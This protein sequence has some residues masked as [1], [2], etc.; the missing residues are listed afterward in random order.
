MKKLFL[1]LTLLLLPLVLAQ[2]P[3]LEGQS[4]SAT[5]PCEAPN[6][7]PEG[8]IGD[9]LS[10]LPTTELKLNYLSKNVILPNFTWILT[11]AFIIFILIS[12]YLFVKK[13]NKAIKPALIWL[14]LFAII[15]GLTYSVAQYYAQE[16]EG[17]V[18]V[19]KTSDD[20]AISMH[21]HADIEVTV[22][23]KEH[24]FGFEKGPLD[25][26]HTHKEKNKLHWH[27]LEK[28]DPVTKEVINPTE[29]TL[30]SFFEQMGETFTSTCLLDKC[31]GDLCSDGKKGTVT[32]AVIHKGQSESDR[33]NNQEF[34]KYVWKDGDKIWINFEY[35]QQID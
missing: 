17:G 15:L 31:N 12:A 8:R 4:C 23:G 11:G 14:I 19:C 5:R 1:I 16:V 2:E 20:C 18:I 10:Q 9:V 3:V 22:C 35:L 24:S 7:T 27:D 32:M 25:K 6:I 26:S 13:K 30:G 21:I 33:V 29:L 28:I 34:D